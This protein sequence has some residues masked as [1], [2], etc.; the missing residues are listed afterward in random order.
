MPSVVLTGGASRRS[1]VKRKRRSGSTLVTFPKLPRA[2][3][4]SRVSVAI[5]PPP[6]ASASERAALQNIA[7]RLQRGN[8]T[9]WRSAA[10]TA[11]AT[12]SPVTATDS[13]TGTTV[14]AVP[15][16]GSGV[17]SRRK[18]PKRSRRK[19]LR[20]GILPALIPIIAAAIGAIPGIAGTAVGIAQLKEQQRQFN[21]MY[22]K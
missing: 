12:G 21:E 4:R 11:A 7:Q 15:I 20:G 9:A 3:K 1:K 5:R 2:S 18:T 6:T 14:H 8:F 16:A 10:H 13:A 17:R 22:K 19:T